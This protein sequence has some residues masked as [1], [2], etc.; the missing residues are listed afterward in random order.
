MSNHL[1]ARQSSLI[2]YIAKAALCPETKLVML[3]NVAYWG[4]FYSAKIVES[5]PDIT[6]SVQLFAGL[7]RMGLVKLLRVSCCRY[8]AITDLGKSVAYHNQSI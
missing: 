2:N 1:S 5:L 4:P 8:V 6:D 3:D 7:K